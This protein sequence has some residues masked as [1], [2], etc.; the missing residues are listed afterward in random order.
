MIP[1]P[2]FVRKILKLPLMLALQCG[3]IRRRAA[4]EIKHRWFRDLE[5]S[6]PL[7]DDFSCPIPEL[8]ALYSFSEIFV[9]DEYGSFLRDIPVPRRWIDLGCH[10]GYF[11]LYLAWQ[12]AVARTNEDWHALLID[13]DRRAQAA[14]AATL[15]GNGLAGRCQLLHGAISSGGGSREFAL[16]S[17]MGSSIDLQPAGVQSVTRVP[18]IGPVDILAAFPPPYDLIKIDIEGAEYD[19][20]DAYA[21]VWTQAAAILIEWHGS[22]PSSPDRVR[23]S[24][25]QKAFRFVRILR[26]VR[27]LMI[28]GQAFSSGVQLYRR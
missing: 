11:T 5:L 19:F 23:S 25:E 28:D 7:T 2:K 16:R 17:G 12:H 18:S 15:R 4:F 1:L 26:P 20:L 14:A 27:T 8:D 3:F 22:D 21:E 10:T 6:V 9:T 24:L 13:A